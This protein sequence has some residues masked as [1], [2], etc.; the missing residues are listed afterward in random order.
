MAVICIQWVKKHEEIKLIQQ[1]RNSK[2]YTY[3]HAG[4]VSLSDHVPIVKADI[5]SL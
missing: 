2:T 3:I 1:S 5:Q 4:T